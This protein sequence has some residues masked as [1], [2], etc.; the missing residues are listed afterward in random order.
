MWQE[1]MEESHEEHS[2]GPERKQKRWDN[3]EYQLVCV[4]E[5]EEERRRAEQE[6]K[7]I[8]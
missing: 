7:G 8:L 5:R 4:L 6:G 3:A 2:R 1:R